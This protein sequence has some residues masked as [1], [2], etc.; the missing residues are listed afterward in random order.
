MVDRVKSWQQVKQDQEDSFFPVQGQEDVTLD[1]EL[2]RSSA[3]ESPVRW[4]AKLP[5]GILQQMLWQLHRYRLFHY[6]RQ[7]AEVRH[8]L[9]VLEI[10]RTEGAFLKRG[11]TCATLSCAGSTADVSERFTMLMITSRAHP[12]ASGE[13]RLAWGPI[14][15]IWQMIGVWSWGVL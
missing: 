9:K 14:H 7:E 13:A 6:L 4:L 10:F 5:Q 1:A 11:V 8:R 15:T 12:H 2:G 3:V